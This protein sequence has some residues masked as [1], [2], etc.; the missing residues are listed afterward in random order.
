MRRVLFAAAISLLAGKAT[1]ITISTPLIDSAASCITQS[2]EA[3]RISKNGEYVQF[4]CV[5][6]SAK[7]MF[8]QLSRSVASQIVD[9]QNGTFDNRPF[10]QSACYHGIKG[11]NGNSDSWFRCD[12]NLE[13]GAPLDQ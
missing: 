2:V 3:N 6:S 9:D 4:A 13:I 10:G 11:A 1:A 7:K 5:G 8:D 12:L